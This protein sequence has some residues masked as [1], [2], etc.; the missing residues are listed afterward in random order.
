MLEL[1]IKLF[2]LRFSC[3]FFNGYFL[4]HRH[5]VLVNIFI[6]PQLTHEFRYSIS[7]V[8]LGTMISIVNSKHCLHG[9]TKYSTPTHPV[10]CFDLAPRLMTLSMA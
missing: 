5:F 9:H 4:V 7:P 8:D 6:L 3:S 10:F 2:C 1:I